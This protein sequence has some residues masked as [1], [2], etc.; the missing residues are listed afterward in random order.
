MKIISLILLLTSGCAVN[1]YVG[2]DLVPSESPCLDGT[3]V[4][5]DAAGASLTMDIDQDN[6]STLSI[7]H[8]GASGNY[9]VDQ[10]GGSG[11][12]IILTVNGASA[13][14]DIEQRD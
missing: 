1:R 14:V 2:P 10:T 12:I 4:N 3:I 9:D 5:I 7:H 11:D 13:D 8:D 6:A